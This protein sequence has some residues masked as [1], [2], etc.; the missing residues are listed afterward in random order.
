M[1]DL[2]D[3]KFNGYP[4]YDPRSGVGGGLVVVALF[5]LLCWVTVLILVLLGVVTLG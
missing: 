5:G 4:F 1:A 2:L 3:I